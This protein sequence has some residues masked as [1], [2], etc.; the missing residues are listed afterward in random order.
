LFY[1][2]YFFCRKSRYAGLFAIN[3]NVLTGSYDL[4]PTTNV[5]RI[6]YHLTLIDFIAPIISMDI[7]NVVAREHHSSEEEFEHV[8]ISCY[9]ENKTEPGSSSI[10]Q[11]HMTVPSLY[12]FKKYLKTL[13][14]QSMNDI[15]G[16]TIFNLLN[17][18]NSGSNHSLNQLVAAGGGGS[19]GQSPSTLAAQQLN[20]SAS[21]SALRK[22]NSL[23]AGV[24]TTT[25]PSPRNSGNNSSSS[26][27]LGN[28]GYHDLATPITSVKAMPATIPPIQPSPSSHSQ[29]SLAADF[30]TP[31]ALTA[32]KGDLHKLLG[33]KS[34]PTFASIL[35]PPP[36]L[37]EAP[38]TAPPQPA[39]TTPTAA[40]AATTTTTTSGPASGLKKL[41]SSLLFGKKP[42][43]QSSPSPVSVPQPAFST[44]TSE[45]NTPKVGGGDLL[46]FL[47]ART[48]GQNVN[49]LSML[50]GSSTPSTATQTPIEVKKP[51]VPEVTVVHEPKRE[52]ESFVNVTKKGIQ[53][54]EAGE[55]EEEESSEEINLHS[56]EGDEREEE[57]E[58]EEEAASEV[59]E[60]DHFEKDVDITPVSHDAHHPHPQAASPF[61]A[62]LSATHQIHS[63]VGSGNNN[64]NEMLYS[65]LL[66]M[67][68]EI[69]RLTHVTQQLQ[70][71]TSIV[72]REQ[73]DYH[74]RPISAANSVPVT[75]APPSANALTVDILQQFKDELLKEMKIHQNKSTL[76]I[77]QSMKTTI[78]SENKKMNELIH[79]NKVEIIKSVQETILSE[80]FT[81][82]FSGKLQLVI[83]ESIKENIKVHLS[84]L[85]RNTFENSLLPAFQI[86]CDRLFAQLNMSFENGLKS[87][88]L[89][90]ENVVT[91]A[92]QNQMS[93]QKDLEQEMKN[94]VE[95]VA[96]SE[97]LLVELNNKIQTGGFSS[98]GNNIASSSDSGKNGEKG[99]PVE[100][101]PTPKELLKQ[102]CF[103]CCYVVTRCPNFLF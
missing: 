29:I 58:E 99:A 47:K 27:I 101:P 22:M 65:L 87:L 52:I 1:Y 4:N 40:S 78:D 18:V 41:D 66:D 85:F 94:L 97:N 86:G 68:Q 92:N 21:S 82:Q 6:L 15:K 9:Q 14:N 2:Y 38:V 60:F 95:K 61:Q 24:T 32:D 98:A 34:T 72:Q 76:H 56:N 49:I 77:L 23:D 17:S 20:S 69:T 8:E 30:G 100:K 28:L 79:Q 63:I 102:V 48:P 74:S 71:E 51:V 19:G 54:L 25:S 90:M 50:K 103:S 62:A 7:I 33:V 59:P 36:A 64:N 84:D 70:L 91:I 10:Q 55:I 89:E 57:E 75:P 37:V 46:G 43:P 3:P 26:N 80:K 35:A 93:S 5:G 88:I 42:A 12:D 11:Y 31:Q 39:I 67:K 53:N 16:R 83:K 44:E 73:K 13:E 81:S 96:V 45:N